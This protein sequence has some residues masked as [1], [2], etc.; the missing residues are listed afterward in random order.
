M[1]A[2]D[3]PPQINTPNTAPTVQFFR[4]FFL[5]KE[6]FSGSVISIPASVYPSVC[7][8]R[9]GHSQTMARLLADSREER[10][11]RVV[12]DSDE[13]DWAASSHFPPVFLL[14]LAAR[15]KFSSSK[16]AWSVLRQEVG[17]ELADLR[18]IFV[19]AK[20]QLVSSYYCEYFSSSKTLQISTRH[21]FAT[22]R[23]LRSLA[24]LRNKHRVVP[25]LP[26]I[27]RL[28]VERVEPVPRPCSFSERRLEHG[29]CSETAH[30]IEGRTAS[31]KWQAAAV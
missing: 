17:L 5:V 24:R 2:C 20:L 28:C 15:G 31:W 23:Y 1:G 6:G 30:R 27:G 22:C 26:P 11:G 19:T 18:A 29:C 9:V 4:E 12:S 21:S 25:C 8:S 16:A 10:S 7:F 3:L 13:V 14:N